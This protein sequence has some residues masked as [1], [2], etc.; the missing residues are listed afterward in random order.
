[1]CGISGILCIKQNKIHSLR[2][3]LQRQNKLQN[4]RGPDGESVW[5]HA[6]SLIGFAHRRL[7]IIDL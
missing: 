6:E 4:H 2:Q 7:S 3:K 5:G 1:M